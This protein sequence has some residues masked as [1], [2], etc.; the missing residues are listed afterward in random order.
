MALEVLKIAI[1]AKFRTNTFVQHPRII[2]ESVWGL[3]YLVPNEHN[4]R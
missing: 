1:S 4:P 2:L 3:Y